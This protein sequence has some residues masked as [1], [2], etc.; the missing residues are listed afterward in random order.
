[1]T[2]TLKANISRS[3][4]TQY[5]T[6]WRQAR[7]L[8]MRFGWNSAAYQILNTEMELWFTPDLEGCVG[9]VRRCGVRVVV[10]APVCAESRIAQIAAAFEEDASREG[11]QV[12][13]FGAAAR[14]KSVLHS[15]PSHSFLE[16]GAQPAWNPAHWQSI[17]NSHRSLRAQLHR[18]K[19]KGVEVREYESSLAAGNRELLQCY[20]EWRS[21]HDPLAL[22]FLTEAVSLKNL[23]DRRLFVAEKNCVP[24]SFLIATPVPD[25]NGWLIEQ[26]VRGRSAPNGT[27][28]LL[29][30]CAMRAFAD[31]RSEYAT[32]GLA[33]LSVR[34][35]ASVPNPEL[36][37]RMLLVWT[38]KHGTRF[39][40]FEGLDSFKA[41]FKPDLWEPIYA[42]VNE[43]R[44]S[45][46]TL[47]AIAAAF[48]NEPP[49]RV[50]SRALTGAIR[51]ELRWLLKRPSSLK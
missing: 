6:K 10:G 5:A 27:S 20:S 33:P 42:I 51:Q 15:L 36:W 43:P 45:A 8:V 41:K 9:F 32:L 38:R 11:E 2:S 44:F 14:L 49:F 23:S 26:I 25:R 24:V 46:R 21:A 3:V 50:A 40:N 31:S 34:A 37:L 28:E 39:Y 16:I 13:Y 1:M 30:D 4:P 22:G 18:S 19:N 12:C 29:I 7:D 17:L 35:K 47:Y 48:T